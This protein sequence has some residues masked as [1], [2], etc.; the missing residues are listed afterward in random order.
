LQGVFHGVRVP[1]GELAPLHGG[2]KKTPSPPPCSALAIS[3]F[4]FE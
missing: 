3:A 4:I 2:V 1:F